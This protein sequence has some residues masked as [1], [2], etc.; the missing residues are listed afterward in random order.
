MG[1]SLAERINLVLLAMFKVGLN[2]DIKANGEVGQ[3]AEIAIQRRRRE[4]KA[5]HAISEMDLNLL[6]L[7]Y[8]AGGWNS[9]NLQPNGVAGPELEKAENEFLELRK[10]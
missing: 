3:E 10:I 4:R 9:V 2:M 5:G 8:K 7:A 6:I 1:L